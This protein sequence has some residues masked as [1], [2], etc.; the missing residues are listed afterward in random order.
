MGIELLPWKVFDHKIKFLIFSYNSWLPV[1]LELLW[2][3]MLLLK[4]VHFTKTSF[5]CIDTIFHNIIVILS[6]LSV[7][8]FTFFI[9]TIVFDTATKLSTSGIY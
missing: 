6:V 5:L 7:V 2:E 3:V 4:I 9:S 1:P 8:V